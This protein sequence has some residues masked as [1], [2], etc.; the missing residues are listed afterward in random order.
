MK[1]LEKL[2]S[3]ELN[4]DEEDSEEMYVPNKLFLR[5]PS[6]SHPWSRNVLLRNADIIYGTLMLLYEREIIYLNGRMMD[7]MW[8]GGGDKL[9]FVC[10]NTICTKS[11]FAPFIEH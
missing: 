4:K 1:K 11:I 2:F 5:P 9:I 7:Y 3:S 10:L 6:K 8:L